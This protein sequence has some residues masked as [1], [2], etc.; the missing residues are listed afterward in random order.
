MV[1]DLIKGFFCIPYQL[2]PNS[3]TKQRLSAMWGKFIQGND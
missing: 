1:L 3:E 2:L